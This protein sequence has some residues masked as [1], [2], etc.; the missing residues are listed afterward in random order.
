MNISADDA[1]VR[2]C[3][4]HAILSVEYTVGTGLTKT[5]E[6]KES[7]FK[8]EQSPSKEESSQTGVNG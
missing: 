5:W 4:Y 7:Y 6:H 3:V 8:G 1:A 2:V